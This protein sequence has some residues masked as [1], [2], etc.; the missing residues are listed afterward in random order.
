MPLKR[1]KRTAKAVI[2]GI[3]DHGREVQ[4]INREASK[5]AGKSGSRRQDVRNA[6]KIAHKKRK[7]RG[8]SLRSSIRNRLNQR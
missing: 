4:G 2:G 7:K 1:V 3:R 5:K 8:T 6:T